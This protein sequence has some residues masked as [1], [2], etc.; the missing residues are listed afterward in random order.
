VRDTAN[1]EAWIEFDARYGDLIVGYARRC[2]LQLIDAEDI[3]QQVMIGL[4]SALPGF[5]YAP[6]RGRFRTYLGR[7]VRHAVSRYLA[8]HKDAAD[9]LS[10]CTLEGVAG[11]EVDAESDALWEQ[12]WVDHHCRRAM[13]VLRESHSQDG[14]RVFEQLLAGQSI[15]DIAASTGLTPEAIRKTKQ[16]IKDR[17]KEIVAEQLRDE[18]SDA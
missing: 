14:I 6:S 8:R 9:V 11:G 10:H 15:S 5:D 17:L 13:Q 16:R 7:A 12:E 2:G 18:H 1:R 4:A 3:R